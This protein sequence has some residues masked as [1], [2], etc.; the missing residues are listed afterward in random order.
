MT[1]R[2]ATD[3]EISDWNT[4]ILT[5][6]D[7]GNIF[8]GFELGEM[9]TQSG[10]KIRYIIVDSYAMTVHERRIPILGTL[11]YVPKGPGTSSPRELK[12]ILDELK[13]FASRCGVF[14][15]KIEPEIIK[16][17]MTIEDVSALSVIPSKPIQPNF[18][19]VI[20]DLSKT[21]DEIMANLPQKS[22]H[23]IKRSFRDGVVIK[24]AEATP[25]NMA[26]MSHLMQVTM[27]DKPGTIRSHDYYESFWKLYADKGLGQL[28]FAYYKDQP[29]AGAFVM[30]Y[31]NKATYKDGGSV[32]EKTVYG[33]SHALQ[34]FIIEWLIQKGITSYDLCGVP[35]IRELANTAHPLYGVGLFKTSFNKKVTEFVG[36]Y[37]VVVNPLAYRLWKKIGERLV[38]RYFLKALKQPFY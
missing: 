9:K 24:T 21:S 37:D 10:W 4:R 32:R 19:T 26:I 8:Q 22:R 11:W 29:V 7:G 18:S 27:A 23:A 17:D 13:P 33:A 15:I 3:Q 14:V 20:L 38:F 36:L 25:D 16:N 35:P 6:P 1:A 30:T 28:F 2:F 12:K 34:W 31:G 5:N